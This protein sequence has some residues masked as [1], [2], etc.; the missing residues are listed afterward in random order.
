MK[1]RFIVTKTS[2]DC[3]L[4]FV[5]VFVYDNSIHRY[6]NSTFCIFNALLMQKRNYVTMRAQTCRTIKREYSW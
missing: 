4:L 2:V 5:F 6:S 1:K 3:Y